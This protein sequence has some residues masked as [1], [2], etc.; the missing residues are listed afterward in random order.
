MERDKFIDRHGP[1]TY[2]DRVYPREK[3]CFPFSAQVE[4]ARKIDERINALTSNLGMDGVGLKDAEF[5]FKKSAQLLPNIWEILLENHGLL[6]I[7]YNDHNS[8]G[9][10]AYK[11]R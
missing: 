4:A 11:K 2:L 7:D 10:K 6:P 8:P 3:S 1:D 9:Y 5:E